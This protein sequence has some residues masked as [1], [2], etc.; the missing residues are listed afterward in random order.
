M[1]QASTPVGAGLAL[2]PLSLH[3][4]PTSPARDPV[5]A[6]DSVTA[7]PSRSPRDTHLGSW[8][9]LGGPRASTAA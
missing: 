9:V 5:L 6:M 2:V 7:R 3:S 4:L 1:P 8:A